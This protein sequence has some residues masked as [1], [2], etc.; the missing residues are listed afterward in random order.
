MVD[1]VAAWREDHAY[2]SRLLGLLEKQLALFSSGG[3]PNYGLMEDIVRY[4]HDFSDQVHHP[5]EDVAFACIAKRNPELA[6]ELERL[7]REHR[8]IVKAGALLL[9]LLEE[10]EADAVF[11]RTSLEAVASTYLTY[12]RSHIAAEEREVLPRAAQALAPEDW[13]AVAAAVPARPDPLFG[14]DPEERYR[15][16]RRQIALEA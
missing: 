4:L 1:P 15:T 5:R 12:Y 14:K 6:R 10:I 3:Q 9:E 7:Q 8:V 13:K 16:L 2:F 11:P